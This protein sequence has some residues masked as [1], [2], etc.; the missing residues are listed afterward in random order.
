MAE[1]TRKKMAKNKKQTKFS[2]NV[3][4]FYHPA[5]QCYMLYTDDNVITT[6][7]SR[8]QVL[9]PKKVKSK[10]D[11]NLIC[12]NLV[13]TVQNAQKFSHT[14]KVKVS[15]G[16]A[17]YDNN[18]INN[19]VVHKLSSDMGY[20]VSSFSPMPKNLIVAEF[21]GE[22]KP[23][24]SK[25]FSKEYG[26]LTKTSSKNNQWFNA[27]NEVAIESDNFDSRTSNIDPKTYGNVARFFN[28]CPKEHENSEVLTANLDVT[29]WPVSSTMARVFLVTNRAIKAGEPLCW[30]YGP[31]YEHADMVLLNG[32]TFLPIEEAK[33]DL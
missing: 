33:G 22:R 14:H 27:D 6:D 19:L 25:S 24:A 13:K 32:Q 10:F 5:S 8:Y 4:P 11:L 20:G 23:Y 16:D 7:E 28:H 21:V 9:S 2:K 3:A 18:A 17:N 12:E 31:T 26:F 30:D 15:H 1:I 29:V